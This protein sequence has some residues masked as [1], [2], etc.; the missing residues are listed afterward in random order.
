VTIVFQSMLAVFTLGLSLLVFLMVRQVGVLSRRLPPASA[1]KTRHQMVPGVLSPVLEFESSDGKGRTRIPLI[2]GRPTYLLF[3]SFTCS[4]CRPLLEELRRMPRELRPRI[5]LMM[6]DDQVRQRFAGEI[7][8]W[9]LESWVIVESLSLAQKFEISE[10]PAVF[11][12]DAEG[13]MMESEPV[14]SVGDLEEFMRLHDR[15]AA[16]SSE[17]QEAAVGSAPPHTPSNH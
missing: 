10:A 16:R 7:A 11:A 6:L 15:G 5:I 13:R 17:P 12:F 2:E 8:D 3:A 9:A 4:L 14:Y 1:S